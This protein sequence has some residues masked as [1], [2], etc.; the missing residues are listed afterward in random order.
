[1]ATNKLLSYKPELFTALNAQGFTYILQ[2]EKTSWW[3]LSKRIIEHRIEIP[4]RS[5][6]KAYFDIW[7]DL[8]KTGRDFK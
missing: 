6:S 5:N 3:G 7:D 8:I 2:I 4:F 1:M